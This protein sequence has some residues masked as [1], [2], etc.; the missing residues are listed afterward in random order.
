MLGNVEIGFTY[1]M[2]YPLLLCWKLFFGIERTINIQRKEEYY[3]IGNI[4]KLINIVLYKYKYR[5]IW[6]DETK[7]RNKL[8]LQTKTQLLA[9]LWNCSYDGWCLELLTHNYPFLQVKDQLSIDNVLTTPWSRSFF[10][11]ILL[12][13]FHPGTQLLQELCCD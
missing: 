2:G 7:G 4:T 12:L 5:V 9:W 1:S 13:L 8:L 3:W 11:L 6:K 10:Q